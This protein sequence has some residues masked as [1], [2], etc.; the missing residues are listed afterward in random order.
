MRWL[1]ALLLVVTACT[2]A[3][4]STTSEPRVADVSG[5][6]L[7]PS[8]VESE[9]PE[10]PEVPLGPLAD[11]VD[12]E[13]GSI[14]ASIQAGGF[15]T[16]ALGAISAGG[17]PRVSWFLADLLR[18]F[19][20][21]STGGQIARV[22]ADLTG[23]TVDSTDG[24]AFVD[25]FN[26]LIA[27]NLPAWDGYEQRKGE[28]Y[29]ILDDRW[30]PF[31]DEN[32]AIDWRWVTWGGV[33]LDDRPLGNAD[34]CLRGCIPALDDPPTVSAE[35]VTWLA[36]SDV[37]FGI[38]NGG[39]SL[40]LPRHQMEVHEMV[41]LTLGGDRFGI[42]YCTLCGSAQAYLTESV[43]DGFET[44]VLR[45]SGLLS[46]S[47]KV[48]FDLET[49]SVFDTFTGMAL[50]GP[51]GDRGLILP[52]VSVTA[53]TWGDWKAAH[54]ETRV[55]AE[56]GGIGRTYERNPLGD[57]DANGPIFP[58]GPVDPRLPVQEKV[59]GV[60]TQDGRAVAFPVSGVRDILVGGGTVEIDDLVVTLDGSGLAVTDSG[61]E[62]VAHEAFWFAWSQFHPN[63][64]VWSSSTG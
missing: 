34:P 13:L 45:T 40:A 59:V 55:I 35:D 20:D 33:L 19:Q 22:F 57:R 38:T 28:L 62:L 10:A 1:S 9:Y 25:V 50:S 49:F 46:R 43:P 64:L 53:S 51:L 56:D 48:M 37:V 44:V 18:F 3:V 61:G 42:P 58:V 2:A 5:R 4:D 29:T 30:Q 63:T 12:N 24:L 23:V 60:T 6:L 27:W 36:E 54:P 52:Q 7:E 41:N 8:Q 39:E 11:S 15:D 17:D 21:A 16:E 31:F 47:N 26:H 14:I 32:V